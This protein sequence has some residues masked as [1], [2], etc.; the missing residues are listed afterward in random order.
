VQPNYK[1]LVDTVMGSTGKK[2]DGIIKCTKCKYRIFIIKDIK[3]CL[4][5]SFYKLTL[6]CKR[7]NK[8]NRNKFIDSKRVN[9]LISKVKV[10]ISI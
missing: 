6:T 1:L 2:T 3:F 4:K 7:C 9:Y 5:D 10:A 8:E